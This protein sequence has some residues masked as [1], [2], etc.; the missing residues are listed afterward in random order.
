MA[1]YC[2]L[3]TGNIVEQTVVV[4]NGVITDKF[5]VEHEHLG[6]QFLQETFKSR[7]IWKKT[8]YNTRGGIHQL[9][10][11]PFRKNFAGVG[12]YYDF[13][14]DAFIPIKKYKSW[15]LNETTCRWEAPTAYPTDGERYIWNETAATWDLVED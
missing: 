5:G 10:G 6:E 1:H 9:G 13:D 2:K 7:D 4:A 14:R 3:G 12:Y 8:S 11:T 15:T